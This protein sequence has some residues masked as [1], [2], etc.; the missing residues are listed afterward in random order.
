MFYVKGHGSCMQFDCINA[1]REFRRKMFENTCNTYNMFA[2]INSE[3]VMLEPENFVVIGLT[4]D[5][6]RQ[7]NTF[8]D[9]NEYRTKL[10]EILSDPDIYVNLGKITQSDIDWY[11]L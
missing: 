2:K 9:A 11:L 6:F 5:S 4:N 3:E 7:I 1:E 10:I 8:E